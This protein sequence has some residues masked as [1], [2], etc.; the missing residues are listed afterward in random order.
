MTER[1]RRYKVVRRGRP[2][3]EPGEAKRDAT[4]RHLLARALELFQQ[5]GVEATT[6]RD[7][8]R[9]AGMSLGAAYYYFPSK[10][11]LVFAY[12]EANQ[13]EME[14]LA[15][16]ATGSL[17]E[18]LGVL[19]HGKLASIRPQRR[20]LAAIVSRLVDPSDP[21]GA[22]SQASRAVRQR[23]IRLLEDAL[24]DSGLPEQTIALAAHGLWLAQLAILLVY[25]NDTSPGE[26]RSHGLV[27]D[28][29]DLIVPLAP[30]F[31]TPIGASIVTR[32]MAAL[33]RAGIELVPASP[34]S[35]V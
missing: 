22:F 30:M 13:D 9:A 5:R 19:F 27:D 16:S 14:A 12:Y 21:L 6:M 31:G 8:A 35:E 15:A 20:M 10:E 4:R 17:R 2:R 32:V 26:R 18:R 23:A 29:L 1:R 11:A 7:I 33:G 34:R 3:R 28:L 24:A 25:V